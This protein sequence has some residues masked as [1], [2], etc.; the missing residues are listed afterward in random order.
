M[1]TPPKL[2]S[3]RAEEVIA[4]HVTI[5]VKDP[6]DHDAPAILHEPRDYDA[7]EVRNGAVIMISGAGGGVSGPSGIT[8]RFNR[9]EKLWFIL[10]ADRDISVPR[11]QARNPHRSPCHPT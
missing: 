10:T 9:R 5:K 1:T 4:R 11:R 2:G 6:L 7:A 3:I 8:S